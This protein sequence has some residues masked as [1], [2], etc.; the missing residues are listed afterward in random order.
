MLPWG[1]FLSS[2]LRGGGLRPRLVARCSLVKPSAKVMADYPCRDGEKKRCDN[3]FHICM[4]LLPVPV[5]R[6]QRTKYSILWGRREGAVNV[7]QSHF[8]VGSRSWDV[9][10]YAPLSNQRR[11]CRACFLDGSAAVNVDQSRFAVG[12]RSWDVF[13]YDLFANQLRPAGLLLG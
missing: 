12:S 4:H 5:W 6:R 11:P 1:A 8:A 13:A 9:F 3:A 2:F 7:S 10:A